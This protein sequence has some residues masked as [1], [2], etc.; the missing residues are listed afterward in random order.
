LAGTIFKKFVEYEKKS[1]DI[2][3][4]KGIF[5]PAQPDDSFSHLVFVLLN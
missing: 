4:E 1:G 5:L 3:K 2:K